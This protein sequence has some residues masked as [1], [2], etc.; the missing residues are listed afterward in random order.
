MSFRQLMGRYLRLK[1]EL[2][3]V[4]AEQPSHQ[5]RI[6]RLTT[7]IALTGSE[8]IARH[9]ANNTIAVELQRAA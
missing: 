1:Q 6:D 5:A 3:T 8:I 2:A 9:P 7:D 4:R